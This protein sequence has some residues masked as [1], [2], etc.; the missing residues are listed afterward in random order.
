MPFYPPKKPKNQN[1]EKW[2]ILL[3]NMCTK[4]D[5]HMMYGSWDKDWHRQNCLSFWVIFCPLT[6][7]PHT[8]PPLL[9]IPKIKILKKKM[10]KMPGNIILLYTNVYHKRKSYD[11]WFLKY[12][13]RLTEIFVI[14]GHF[15]PCQSPWQPGKSKF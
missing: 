2:K 15:L 12:K 1:F 5:N 11:I 7:P 13:V 8:L 3:V 10:K 4:N 14:L 6:P 9:M